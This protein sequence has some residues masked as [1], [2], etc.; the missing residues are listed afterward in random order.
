MTVPYPVL[1]LHTL[2]EPAIASSI[3]D[4]EVIQ[5]ESQP[6]MSY[7]MEDEIEEQD[8]QD[9][10]ADKMIKEKKPITTKAVRGKRGRSSQ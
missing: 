4:P 3:H 10:R 5:E 8:S 2:R 6:V 1:S 7:D 9:I